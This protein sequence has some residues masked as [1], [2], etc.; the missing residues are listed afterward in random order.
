MS[1]DISIHKLYKWGLLGDQSNGLSTFIVKSN[2]WE[3]K[4]FTSSSI[5]YSAAKKLFLSVREVL[6]VNCFFIS[7]FSISTNTFKK[8]WLFSI[9]SVTEKTPPPAILSTP[10]GVMSDHQ[11]KKNNV[12]GEIL[13]E[14]F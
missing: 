14:V 1:S 12:G 6:M 4:A 9:R 2:D 3:D 5:I 10:K 8:A 7:S 13:C 11:A